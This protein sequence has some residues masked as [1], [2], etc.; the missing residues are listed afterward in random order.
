MLGSLLIGLGIFGFGFILQNKFC[1][2][3]E[4]D[5]KCIIEDKEKYSYL[6]LNCMNKKKKYNKQKKPSYYH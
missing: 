1:N 3:T 5:Y 6:Q 4:D 2:N